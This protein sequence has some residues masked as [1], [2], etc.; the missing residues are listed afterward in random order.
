MKKIFSFIAAMLVAFS[1]NLQAKTVY[2]QLSGDWQGYTDKYAVYYFD[3]NNDQTVKGWSAL[4]TEVVTNSVYTTTIPDTGYDKLIFVRLDNAASEGSWE[5]RWSQTVNLDYP[6]GWDNLFTVTSGGTGNECN[7]EW[8]VYNLKF[9]ITGNE[10]LVGNDDWSGKE[11]AV[12]ENSYTFENLPAGIYQCKIVTPD[13]DWLGYS[14]LTEAYKDAAIYTDQY[15]NICFKLTATG[16]V[17]IT[18]ISGSVFKLEGDFV[19]PTVQLIGLKG[20]GAAAWDMQNAITMT[21]SLDKLTASVTVE[22]TAG[23]HE[24][25]FVNEGA[26]LG[27][28]NN[29]GLYEINR[30][31]TTVSGLTYAG[32][33]IKVVAD[34]DEKYT[35]T[36]TFATGTMEV[37]YPI[38]TIA[39][40]GDFNSWD[41]TANVMS[42]SVDSLTASVTINLEMNQN[43]GYG[44]KVV[45]GGQWRCH[46][47][48]QDWWT[49]TPTI[50]S[51]T[52][53]THLATGS[54]A[55]WLH[56]EKG[57]SYTFI[58]TFANNGLEIEYPN[59]TA[60]DNTEVGEKAVKRIENGQLVI[61]KNGVKY[62]ALGAEVK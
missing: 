29:D 52:N 13:N 8:S 40:A 17:T 45:V 55:F 61:I 1:F 2:L 44:F 38:P 20:E 30:Y 58:W 3:S 25:R 22:L 5:S 4:M 57:G 12:T 42:Y 15:G 31:W 33:N 26:W 11:I 16:N 60:I 47:P 28:E 59:A 62:N 49:F 43:S 23:N 51:T 24:F 37:T 18:Y 6:T 9:Y 32:E 14:A 21:P 27:K 7:G 54:E 10:N 56:M 41:E 36:W 39:I 34:K 46:E 19:L 50:T 53:I 48:G 35:F